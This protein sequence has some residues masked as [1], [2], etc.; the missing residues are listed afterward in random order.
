MR[1]E[2]IAKNEYLIQFLRLERQKVLT[3][4]STSVNPVALAV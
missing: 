3:G 2:L 4:T 1:D